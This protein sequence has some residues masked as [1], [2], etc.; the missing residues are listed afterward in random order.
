MYE[1]EKKGNIAGLLMMFVCL[2]LVGTLLAYIYVGLLDVVM[3]IYVNPVIII[4]YGFILAF[5]VI[6]LKRIFKITGK[7]GS[8][9]VVVLALA[10]INFMIWAMFFGMWDA[11]YSGFELNPFLDMGDFF[12]ALRLM[13]VAVLSNPSML[14]EEFRFFNE[15]GTWAY[16]DNMVT[17]GILAALW[18]V[19]FL[20]INVLSLVAAVTSV[21]FF[22]YEKNAWATPVFYGYRFRKID[23]AV[24]E[25]IEIGTEDL[26]TVL[27]AALI[28]PDA[29]YAGEE[30]G[31]AVMHHEEQKTDYTGIY[32]MDSLD[33]NKKKKG[34]INAFIDA[35]VGGDRLVKAI[36]LSPDMINS[37]DAQLLQKLGEPFTPEAD[38]NNE[39]SLEISG[40]EADDD[41]DAGDDD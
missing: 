30:Y 41:D 21:G 18:G 26:L 32:R 25:R 37:L 38:E 24:L 13:L 3:H 1:T 27:E 35:V 19:E 34:V 8:I 14:V 15:L 6:K 39:Q 17:G 22:L 12:E 9:I 28:K 40:V 4:A 5:L 31:L 7:V 16:N 36:K 2:V 33:E 10:V 20:L 23:N 29:I 11:R